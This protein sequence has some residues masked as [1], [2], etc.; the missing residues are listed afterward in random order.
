MPRSGTPREFVPTPSVP[1]AGR[2]ARP[3]PVDVRGRNR[4]HHGKDTDVRACPQ[5]RTRGGDRA[6]FWAIGHADLRPAAVGGGGVAGRRGRHGYDDRSELRGTDAGPPLQPGDVVIRDYLTPHQNAPVTEPIE[7]AGAEVVPL[8]PCSSDRTPIE[9]LGSQ[10]KESRRAAA[11][12]TTDASEDARGVALRTVCPED[13]LGWF[14]CGGGCGGPGVRSPDPG[15]S[16]DCGFHS[17]CT[18]CAT[19]A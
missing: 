5:A 16:N 10:A 17:C 9:E 8:P 2:R 14:R 18:A 1:E 3:A 11:A 19:Q 7:Q 12:R 15:Y 13:I 6:R 4:N